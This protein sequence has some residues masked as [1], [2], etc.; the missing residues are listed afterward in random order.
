MR[1]DIRVLG[2]AATLSVLS[3]KNLIPPY[4]VGGAHTGEGNRFVVMRGG[5]IEPTSPIPGKIGGFALARDDIVRIETAGGG[6]L[7]DPLE[8]D[9]ALVADD[10][11]LGYTTSDTARDV[12]GAVIDQAGEVDAACTQR[13][14]DELKR[15]RVVVSVVA[16][17][18]EQYDG[19][20]RIFAVGRSIADA[21]RVKDGDLCELVNIRGPNLRG[22][23]RV[24]GQATDGDALALGPFGRAILRCNE[25]DRYVLRP[26]RG[27]AR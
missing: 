20:R 17:P 23:I 2:N 4:G 24:D 6:A 14:R 11:R 10:V 3:D 15:Q 22:W 1:R 26:L 8:R 19:A 5:T 27:A 25:R 12:Y 9:P 13:L 18:D 16:A 21:L 7:G